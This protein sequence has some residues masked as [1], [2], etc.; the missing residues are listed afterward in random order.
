MQKIPYDFVTIQNIGD[1]PMDKENFV[2]RAYCIVD[3][4]FQKSLGS[5]KLRQRGPAPK[6]SDSEVITMQVVGEFLQIDGDK[7]I[8]EYFK[9]NWSHFFPS[10]GHRSSFVKQAGNLWYYLT[11][12]VCS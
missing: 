5:R 11:P 3:D 2:I 12:L 9:L 7:N 4:F 6:L 8:W 10:I 1:C